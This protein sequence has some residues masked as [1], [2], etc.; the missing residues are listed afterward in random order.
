M[1]T[2]GK[3]FSIGVEPPKADI[4]KLSIEKSFAQHLIDKK[5]GD[6]IDFGN[7]FKILDIKKYI[8]I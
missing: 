5:I 4:K 3:W 1:I 7:G 8:S 2:K 6:M